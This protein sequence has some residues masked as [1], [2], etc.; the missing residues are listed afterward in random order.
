MAEKICEVNMTV[1][2]FD[3]NGYQAT[4]HMEFLGNLEDKVAVVAHF[5]EVI[6]FP[7]G[8]LGAMTLGAAFRNYDRV[9]TDE[10]DISEAE[11]FIEEAEEWH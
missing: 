5:L 4:G 7:K 9:E 8:F 10:H 3:E 6:K 11:K 1:E 2:R